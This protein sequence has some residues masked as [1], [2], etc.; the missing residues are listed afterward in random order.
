MHDRFSMCDDSFWFSM[1][2]RRALCFHLVVVFV[3]PA[4]GISTWGRGTMKAWGTVK[5]GMVVTL[6]F[7]IVSF[8][9]SQNDSQRLFDL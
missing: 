9:F 1:N 6:F 8:I 2:I 5:S 4:K 7:F 3:E